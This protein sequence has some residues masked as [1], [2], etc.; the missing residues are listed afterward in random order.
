MR[1]HISAAHV[2]TGA[3]RGHSTGMYL[4]GS[5]QLRGL[6]K[7]PMRGTHTIVALGDCG[8]GPSLVSAVVVRLVPSAST[9][10]MRIASCREANTM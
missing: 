5:A 2:R 8:R 6:L 10:S 3:V 4:S 1:V 9:G 7:S